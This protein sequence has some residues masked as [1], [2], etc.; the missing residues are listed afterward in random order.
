MGL[1]G[2]SLK[3][4][5]EGG[6]VE[7][8]LHIAVYYGGDLRLTLGC[9]VGVFPPLRES[10]KQ[11]LF[12][13]FYILNIHSIIVLTFVC[14]LFLTLASNCFYRQIDWSIKTNNVFVCSFG[15]DPGVITRETTIYRLA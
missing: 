9:T 5:W 4:P 12:Q 14:V 2:E 13:V 15:V 1:R 3:G 10:V 6:H 8:S 11:S 7:P